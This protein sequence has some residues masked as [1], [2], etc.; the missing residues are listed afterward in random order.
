[1]EIPKKI[2]RDKALT[3]RIKEETYEKLCELVKKNKVKVSQ[4]DVIEYL[5][6]KAHETLKP[7]RK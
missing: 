7:K 5:I 2:K 3:V 1:M 6:N 4:A